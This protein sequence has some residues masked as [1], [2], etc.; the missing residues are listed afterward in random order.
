MNAGS[1]VASLETSASIEGDEVLLNGEKIWITNGGVA[2]IALVFAAID[3]ASRHKGIC[4]YLVETSSAGFQS[5]PMP[6]Q[7]LGHRASDHAVIRLL[8]CRIPAS[9]LLGESGDGFKVAMSALDHGRLGV[10]A[11]AVGVAQSC[12]EASVRFATE[13]RQFGKRIGDFEMIQA[14]IADMAAEVEAARMLVLRAAWLK[15]QNQPATQATSMAK[16]YA[17]EAAARA[18][19]E[20]ILIHGGRGYSDEYPVERYL[21]DIKGHQIYEGT[22]HIQRIIVARELIGRE[23]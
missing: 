2:Q 7:E 17:T 21:R 19:N 4:A 13:R 1:D 16:L 14:S 11:G 9:A 15:D 8:N 5:E 18:A 3:P 22:S 6:G 20:A 23:P 12:L 10:A